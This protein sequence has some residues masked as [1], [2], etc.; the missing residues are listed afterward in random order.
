[1]RRVCAMMAAKQ[2]AITVPCGKWQLSLAAAQKMRGISRN[3]NEY[4]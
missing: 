3:T 4:K 1:M 2:I